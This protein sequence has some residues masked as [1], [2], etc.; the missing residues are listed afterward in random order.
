MMSIGGLA[1]NTADVASQILDGT[2]P[3]SLRTPPQSPGEPIFD[4]RELR[5]WD[6]PE[7]RLPPG[8]VVQFRG[9]SLWDEYKRAVLAAIG[10]LVLQSLLIA[11]LLYERRARQLGSRRRRGSTGDDRGAD[12]VDRP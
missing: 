6:I 11:W 8:S 9:P 10:V 3:R 5:R 1:R 2:P 4:W 7:S 12:F